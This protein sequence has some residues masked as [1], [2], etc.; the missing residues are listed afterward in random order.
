[1]LSTAVADQAPVN[2]N[3]PKKVV[4]RADFDN[5]K[6]HGIIKFQAP[7]GTVRVHVDLTGLPEEGGPFQYHIHKKPV[8]ESGD[9]Y[10]TETHFNPYNA[11][12]DCEAQQD[13]SYCQVGDLSG[14]HGFINT[15]CFETRYWDPYLSLNPK[16]KAYPVGLSINLH[17]ANLTRFACANIKIS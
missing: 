2:S 15:T 9:C 5:E 12:P 4:A 10:A 17:Y 11:P 8:P 7:N 3:S 1:L 14:K 6:L 16:S 13:D